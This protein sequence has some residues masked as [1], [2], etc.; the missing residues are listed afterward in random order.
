MKIK[1]RVT[2]YFDVEL[3]LENSMLE[4]ELINFRQEVMNDP[5]DVLLEY[6]SSPIVGEF[7]FLGV[8]K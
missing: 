5:L 4:D 8:I 1:V 7:E 2:M 3:P 6:Q